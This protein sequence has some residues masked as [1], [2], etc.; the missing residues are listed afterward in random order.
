MRQIFLQ[1]FP[2]GLGACQIGAIAGGVVGDSFGPSH[3]SDRNSQGELRTIPSHHRSRRRRRKSNR[4]FN[5]RKYQRDGQEGRASPAAIRGQGQNS[6][7]TKSGRSGYPPKKVPALLEGKVPAEQ[8]AGFKSWLVAI[9]DKVANAG[10]EGGFL[11]FGGERVSA[12]E[13]AAI[14]ELASTLGAGLKLRFGWQDCPSDLTK[15]R[16]S[17][18]R[19]S[20]SDLT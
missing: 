7:A 9:A 8:A 14:K 13:S 15:R 16:V 12:A 19:S 17:R 2:R 1:I 4:R 11:G 18:S 6:R 20:S 3:R 10:K 5:R